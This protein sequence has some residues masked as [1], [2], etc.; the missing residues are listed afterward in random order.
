MDHRRD[1][2]A[3]YHAAIILAYVGVGG[4]QHYESRILLAGHT[5]AYAHAMPARSALTI[6]EAMARESHGDDV[7]EWLAAPPTREE[8][9]AS[10]RAQIVM[11]G[12]DV[13]L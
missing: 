2:A 13:G 1:N 6:I 11:L 8:E 12:G 4:W 10:L 3:P 9:D 7:D 5:A